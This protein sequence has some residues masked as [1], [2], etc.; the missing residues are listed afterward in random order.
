M[1]FTL[2]LI[3]ISESDKEEH[4]FW[5]SLVTRLLGNDVNTGLGKAELAQGLRRLRNRSLGGLLAINAVWL[6]VLSYFYMGINS[7]ISRLNIYGLISG[8][9]YGFT[10]CIQIIGL[11]VSR[12]CQCSRKLA[13]QIGGVDAEMY[14]H[15]RE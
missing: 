11:T 12:V 6:G 5:E 14:V 2:N 7:E 9:L 15:K 4:V 3:D 13:E 8:A 10:L 1:T